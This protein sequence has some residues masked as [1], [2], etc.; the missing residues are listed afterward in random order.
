MKFGLNTAILGHMNFEEILQ[1]CQSVGYQSVEVA[2]WPQ[3]KAERRYAGVSHLDVDAI[4]D[5]SAE[6]ILRLCEQYNVEISALAYYPNTLDE[7]LEARDKYINHLKKV[8]VASQKLKVNMVTTFVG[9]MQSK[10]EAENLEEFSKV[11]PDIIRFA[12]EHNVKVAIENCPM[13]FS[14]DEWPGGQNLFTTPAIW[15]QC[16]D[17][18]PDDNFGINYDPS[19]F[20]WQQIDYIKPLYE[21][22]DRI[23]HVHF[24]DI[25]LYKD[26]LDDHG[27]L[28]PPLA[29]MAPKLPGLGDV[30]WGRYV[31]ALRDINF[32]GHACVEVEDKTYEDTIKDVENSC[33]LCHRYL[34]QFMI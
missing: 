17:I 4:T 18:I 33:I 29:Y 2:C 28:A 7:N 25:K 1:F 21:F 20:I 10:N 15:R 13:L 34:S 6:E 31:S 9:R 14:Y 5:E 12:K 3:G 23:F 11:W 22:S 24:K 16:F 27:V 8:I 30:D 19:H 32:K 26:K